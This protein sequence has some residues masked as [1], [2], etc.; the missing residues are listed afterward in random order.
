LTYRRASIEEL[1][2]DEFDVVSVFE[3]VEHV[4]EPARFLAR[5]ADFVRPGGWLVLSTI[6]RT[7][8][9]WLTTNVVAED[10]LR[11]VPKGTHDWYKYINEEE[12]AAFFGS[13]GGWNSPRCAG[14]VYVPG[15]GWKEVAGSE[16]L[17][18]YLWGVRRDEP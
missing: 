4:D 6:A 17:G 15:L 9:S 10:I 12:L 1:P 11:I 3:V 8:A 18:N 14:L 13:R 5:C 16:K 7:W 2:G